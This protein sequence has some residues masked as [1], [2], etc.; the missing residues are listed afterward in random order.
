MPTF[1][2]FA[3]LL[4]A[5]LFVAAFAVIQYRRPSKSVRA[6]PLL[7][8]AVAWGIYGVLEFTAP[9]D[10]NLALPLVFLASAAGIL[11]AA[12]PKRGAAK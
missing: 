6:W 1:S 9:V 4:I 3:L 5:G 7:I 10:A 2:P 11:L 8:P 12:I